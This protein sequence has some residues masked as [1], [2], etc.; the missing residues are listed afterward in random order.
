MYNW[1]AQRRSLGLFVKNASDTHQKAPNFSLRDLKSMRVS[2]KGLSYT[3]YPREGLHRQQTV[4]PV[5]TVMSD[6]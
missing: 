5:I 4:L 3:G 1:V 2:T 6:E